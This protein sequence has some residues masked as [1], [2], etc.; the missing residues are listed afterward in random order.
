MKEIEQ[1]Q[2]PAEVH[3]MLQMVSM[4]KKDEIQS[5]LN[6]VFNSVS[7]MKERLESIV[8]KDENDKVS[9]KLANTIRLGVRQ[10]RLDADKILDGKRAEVQQLMIGHKTED[11]LWLKVKQVKDLLTKEIETNAKWK[12]DTAVRFLKVQEE[13]KTNAREFS[14]NKFND[15]ISRNEYKDMSDDSFSVFLKALEQAF[16]DEKI[17]AEKEHIEA[18]R[19]AEEQS[20]KDKAQAIE[21]ARIIKENEFFKKQTV[22]LK[23]P[24]LSSDLEKLDSLMEDLKAISFKYSFDSDSNKKIYRDVGILIEKV[25]NHIIVKS[26]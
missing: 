20:L 6:N 25:V 13:V 11:S 23:A 4:D 16:N 1:E 18:K 14:V 22:V 17:Q 21:M 8:V 5:V 2:L 12:E 9:M 24:T 26:L 19:L 15:S 7:N 3:Q 10:V